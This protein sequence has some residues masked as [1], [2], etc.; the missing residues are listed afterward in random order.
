MGDDGKQTVTLWSAVYV[1]MLSVSTYL[2][3]D[4]SCYHAWQ[5]HAHQIVEEHV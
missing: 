2:M 1:D 3:P 5:C 4:I